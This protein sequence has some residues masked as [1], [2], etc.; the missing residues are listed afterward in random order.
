MKKKFNIALMALSIILMMT[1]NIAAASFSD[2]NGHWAEEVIIWAADNGFISGYEDGT[3]K[4]QGYI[5][6]AEYYAITNQSTPEELQTNK[7]SA[8]IIKL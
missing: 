2:I 6:R 8:E 3:F 4:P 5:T 7:A 1:S